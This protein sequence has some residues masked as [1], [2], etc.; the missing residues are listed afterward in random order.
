MEELETTKVE[1]KVALCFVLVK[2]IRVAERIQKNYQQL[3]FVIH[4]FAKFCLTPQFFYLIPHFFVLHLS[5][6]F[7]FVGKK[8]NG[9]KIKWPLMNLCNNYFMMMKND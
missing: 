7:S 6:L 9:E 1:T 8:V 5:F 2:I 3:F 4:F